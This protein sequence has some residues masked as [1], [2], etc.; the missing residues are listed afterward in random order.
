MSSNDKSL[1]EVPPLAAADS[2]ILSWVGPLILVLSCLWVYWP[3]LDGLPVWDD[4]S[5]LADMLPLKQDLHGLWR[6]W[7]DPTAM[8]Q[9]YPVTGTSFWI[10]QQLWGNWTRPYHIENVLLHALGAVLLSRLLRR[11]KVPGAWLAG[12][13]FALHPI[14]VESVAWITERKN[15]LS[16]AFMVGSLVVYDQGRAAE[17]AAAERQSSGRMRQRALYCVALLLFLLSLGSKITA[18]VFAPTVL[19]MAWREKGTISWREDVL[20]VMPFLGA[21]IA[22]GGLVWWLETHHVGAEGRDFTTPLVERCAH[23][24]RVFWFYPWKFVWPVNLCFLYP[25]WRGQPPVWQDW[26]WLAAAGAVFAGLW[27]LRRLLGRGPLCAAAFYAIALVPVSG[28]LNVYGGLFAPVWDHWAYVPIAGPLVLLCAS[29][30]SAFDRLN[31]KW[32][33]MAVAIVLLPALGWQSRGQTSQYADKETLWLE[34]IRR[35]PNA[36]LAQNNHGSALVSEGKLEE[37][38]RFFRACLQARPTYSEAWNNLAG[39]LVQLGRNEEALDAYR[40]AISFDADLAPYTRHNLGNALL[41]LNRTDEAIEQFRAALAMKPEYDEALNSLGAALTK[42]GRLDEAIELIQHAIRIKP[43]YHQAHNNLGS[44]LQKKGNLEG[45]RAA[46]EKAAQLEPKFIEPRINLAELLYRQGDMDAAQALH[47]QVLAINPNHAKSNYDLGLILAGQSKL[48]E[49]EAAYR[50]S[51]ASDSANAAAHN[52]LANI[53]L[54]TGRVREAVPEFEQAVAH[55]PSQIAALNN[56]AWVLATDSD[57]AVR[58]PA[59]A[60]ELA[61]SANAL[62]RN[63]HPMVVS[64][65]A[66]ALAE[67]GRYQEAESTA[68]AAHAL[69]EQQGDQALAT[70]LGQ[71]IQLYASHQ[72]LRIERK[73]AP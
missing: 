42:I 63:S 55:D 26:L 40:K 61:R 11:W 54:G 21:T 70:S 16:F 32:A 44:A 36:W 1:T 10:D 53:L 65:L 4:D 47:Q 30:A 22:L 49:A 43:D 38:L 8:Q 59:R 48:A 29:V 17:A 39:A 62:T 60:L 34:T 3:C 69:A 27:L 51:I 58:N 68:R 9:Y 71:Y 5:W 46:Y 64:T 15:V 20:P 67:S 72:P 18:F 50:R 37:S 41:S 2:R 13:V 66:A 7:A 45:A 6:I 12:A 14:M 24:G 19:L 35:N 52:N 23:A 25:D 33:S 73:P 57:A 31:R 56:L 28:L